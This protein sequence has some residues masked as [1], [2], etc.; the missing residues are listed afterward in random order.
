MTTTTQDAPV[1]LLPI[2]Q[3]VEQAVAAGEAES[4]RVKRENEARALQE[5]RNQLEGFG[6]NLRKLGIDP[7]ALAIGEDGPEVRFEFGGRLFRLYPDHHGGSIGLEP[8][9]A[10]CSTGIGS[11]HRDPWLDTYN[12]GRGLRRIADC[13]REAVRDGRAKCW[14]C[15][16]PPEQQ[17]TA[18][19][20]V[21]RQPTIEERL[22]AIVREIALDAAM[23]ARDL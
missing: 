19:P 23:E 20:A 7:A 10:E 6:E 4:A 21:V 16:P 15:D 3:V 18:T 17:P 1:S 12:S 2:E 22:Y 9:C 11:Y 5:E 13:V 14:K 8:V